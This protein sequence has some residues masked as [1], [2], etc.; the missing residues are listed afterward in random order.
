MPQDAVCNTHTIDAGLQFLDLPR[1]F[2]DLLHQTTANAETATCATGVS[3]PQ[4]CGESGSMA[5]MPTF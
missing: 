4:N 2:D 3:A 1:Q 5:V